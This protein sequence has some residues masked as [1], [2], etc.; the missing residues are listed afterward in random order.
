MHLHI[1][2]GKADR[3]LYHK[4]LFFYCG[5]IPRHFS[6]WLVCFFY[7]LACRGETDRGIM[8]NNT[9]LLMLEIAKVIVKGNYMSNNMVMPCCHNGGLNNILTGSL[10]HKWEKNDI[11]SEV[12]LFCLKLN[13]D[14]T[15]W[16]SCCVCVCFVGV[17]SHPCIP[18]AQWLLGWAGSFYLQLTHE[19]V[20]WCK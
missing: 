20:C 17:C 5:S 7:H 15:V 16:A 1:S 13:S 8:L 4:H 14:E 19:S 2:R 6:A 10:C 18:M 3:W 12:M 11:S 9:K